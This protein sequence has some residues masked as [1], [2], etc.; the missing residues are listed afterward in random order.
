MANSMYCEHK[1]ISI[2]RIEDILREYPYIC[3]R[4]ENLQCILTDERKHVGISKGSADFLKNVFF[5]NGSIKDI[6]D[7]EQE[8][9]CLSIIKKTM[10]NALERLKAYPRKGKQL[11]DIVDA[12]YFQDYD[13][14]DITVKEIYCIFDKKLV[15]DKKKSFGFST[16][17]SRRTDAIKLMQPIITMHL[18]EMQT[19]IYNKGREQL[20]NKYSE[21][22][23]GL[24][25]NI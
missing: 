21:M 10:D 23:T 13:D 19:K 14:P 2:D 15:A 20:N 12:I 1:M 3:W 25:A 8:L 7:C 11:Y 6:Y 5:Q 4:I 18:K 9:F 22:P 16:F 17:K 24:V